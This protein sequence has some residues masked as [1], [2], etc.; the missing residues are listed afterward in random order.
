MKYLEYQQQPNSNTLH[1]FTHQAIA[2]GRGKQFSLFGTCN[3]LVVWY[4][5]CRQ[6]HSTSSLFS[7]RC[8][9][10]VLCFSHN[11]LTCILHLARCT[12][13]RYVHVPRRV[14]AITRMRLIALSLSVLCDRMSRTLDELV[15][16]VVILM[17]IG[18]TCSRVYGYR[19]CMLMQVARTYKVN[20]VCSLAYT[21]TQRTPPHCQIISGVMVERNVS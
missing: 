1:Y 10:K 4:N 3:L 9:Y 2:E 16:M 21:L 6:I 7:I 8:A 17:A 15:T 20:F 11:S 12:T 19:S 14:E 18:Y 5:G 13:V